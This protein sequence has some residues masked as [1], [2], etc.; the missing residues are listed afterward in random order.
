MRTQLEEHSVQKHSHSFNTC[1]IWDIVLWIHDA[2]CKVIQTMAVLRR[3][4]TRAQ[5]RASTCFTSCASPTRCSSASRVPSGATVAACSCAPL[6][7]TGSAPEAGAGGAEPAAAGTAG[8]VLFLSSLAPP[9]SSATFSNGFGSSSPVSALRRAS[10]LATS[11]PCA[12]RAGSRL[13]LPLISSFIP[14]I[15]SSSV[16]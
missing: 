5:L 7:A 8:S 3:F 11:R 14:E 2:A 12:T 15:L 10:P 1:I 6:P 13:S 9:L 4:S 16:C